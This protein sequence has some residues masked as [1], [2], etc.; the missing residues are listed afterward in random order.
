MTY[1]SKIIK[2]LSQKVYELETQFDKVTEEN[3][4]LNREIKGLKN[5]LKHEKKMNK[6][7]LKTIESLKEELLI[8]PIDGGSSYETLNNKI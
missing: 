1:L 8:K 5:E 4:E 6:I 7:K 3:Y 2:N